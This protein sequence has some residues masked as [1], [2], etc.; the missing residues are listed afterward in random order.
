[1]SPATGS[2][3]GGQFVTITGTGF[4]TG[5]TVV[6]T[7]ESGGVVVSPSVTLQATSVNVT[8]PL[9]NAAL[10]VFTDTITALSPA[11]TAGTTYYVT[12]VTPNEPATTGQVFT[13]FAQVPTVTGLTVSSGPMTGGTGLTVTGTGFVVGATVNF[14]KV[15]LG[16]PVVL[17]VTVP[18]AS[19]VVT[20]ATTI[21]VTTP[22]VTSGTTYYVSVTTP[23]G[24]SPNSLVFTF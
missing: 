10:G 6:F 1:M 18:A 17:G 11:I 19:A 2:T 24:T 21:E 15:T 8:S 14:I 9:W 4:Q 13:Y 3:G 5:A 20:G 22:A 16:N 12:V 7:E 23:G